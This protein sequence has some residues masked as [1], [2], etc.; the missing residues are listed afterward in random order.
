M[1]DKNNVFRIGKPEI[2]SPYRM[3][4]SLNSLSAFSLMAALNI[5]IPNIGKDFSSNFGPRASLER[6]M[7]TVSHCSSKVRNS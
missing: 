5:I 7:S 6:I 3:K 2:S 4:V 1:A